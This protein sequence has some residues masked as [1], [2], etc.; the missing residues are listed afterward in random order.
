MKS[1]SRYV[2]VVFVLAGMLLGACAAAPASGANKVQADSV[3]FTGTID[4]INGNQWVVN[5]Q[6]VTV[7]PSVIRDGPFNVGD[8]IKIEVN[9]N[10]DG[11]FMVT[12]IEVPSSTDLSSLPPLTNDNS[13]MNS[14]DDNSN[15]NIN[16]DNSNANANTNGN[17]N[18]DRGGN[19]NSVNSN[20]GNSNGSN[21]NGDN[22]N[23]GNEVFGLVQAMTMT[24]ITIDGQTYDLSGAEIKGLVQAGDFV[25]IHLVQNADGTF[26]VREIE[27]SDPTQVGNDNDSNSNSANSNDDKSKGSNSN[28][29]GSKGSNSNDSNSNGGNSN[30]SNSNGSGSSDDNSN[31]GGGHGGGNGNG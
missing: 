13:N 28:D 30:D 27:L 7:D 5:G 2:L 22:S 11:T 8:M 20:D 12:R 24:S 29:N 14:N 1:I 4:S 3:A 21:G 19:S 10:Q 25:K 17:T 9:V 31:G 15:G 16:D 6:A 18:D 26:S 23:G